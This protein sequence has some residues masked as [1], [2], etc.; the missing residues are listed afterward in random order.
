MSHFR[1]RLH[2]IKQKGRRQS[3]PASLLN[4][5]L[6]LALDEAFLEHL[7]VTEPQIGDVG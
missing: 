5:R 7:L 6:I 3:P 1:L 4:C 2:S